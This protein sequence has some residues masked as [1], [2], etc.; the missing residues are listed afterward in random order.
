MQDMRLRYCRTL[1]ALM[2]FLQSIPP[3]FAVDSELQIEINEYSLGNYQQAI[4]MGREIIGKNPGND[5]ARYYLALAYYKSDKFKEAEAEYSTCAQKARDQAVKAYAQKALEN[6]H[7]AFNRAPNTFN[8]AT[9]AFS[10]YTGGILDPQGPTH[11]LT[12]EILERYERLERERAAES[13]RLQT[14][15][16][17]EINRIEQEHEFEFAR[18]R[19][20]DRDRNMA[21]GERP[22]SDAEEQIKRIRTNLAAQLREVD[23]SFAAKASAINSSSITVKTQFRPGNGD[24]QLAPEGLSLYT[25]N[26]VN[27]DADPPPQPVVQELRASAGKLSPTKQK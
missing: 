19:Q 25:K 5:M 6:L 2:L 1:A 17:E 11:R 3:S 21:S 9:G 22:Q 14:A 16:D 12:S 27:Y 26:Y 15:A 18:A 7:S 8:A 13:V 10:T 24:I 4:E 23:R 20:L